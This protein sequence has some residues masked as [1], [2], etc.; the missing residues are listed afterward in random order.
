MAFFFPEDNLQRLGPE[1]TRI[2]SLDAEPYPDGE[3][4]RVNLKL[5]P[6]QIRPQIEVTLTD[7]G[8]ME[9]AAA[10]IVEPMTWQLEFTIHL[11]GAPPG[12]YRIEAHLSYPNG[13]QA[14]TVTRVFDVT[15]SE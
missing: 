14:P 5:T 2:L 4:V 3:R 12:K 11:R 6:F 10:S 15:H 9:V 7:A 8:G 13:P 1:D